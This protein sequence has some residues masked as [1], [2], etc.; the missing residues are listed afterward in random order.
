MGQAED[1]PSGFAEDIGV[2]WVDLNPDRA[3]ARIA[4]EKRHLQ[5]FGT[6]HGGVYAALAESICS[7]ATYDA[8][9]EENMAAMGQSNNTAFLRPVLEG[10]VNALAVARHRGRTT[11]IWDVEMTD[12]QGRL[13]ALSRVTIAVRPRRD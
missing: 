10:S 6:V 5:P 2:D 3:Q 1:M 13:C 11:W 7:A 8:V 9:R 12:D 4:V